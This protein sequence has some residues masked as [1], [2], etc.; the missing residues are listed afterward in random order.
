MTD[1]AATHLAEM[2]DLAA[3]IDVLHHEA[4]GVAGLGRH[5]ESL[6]D[7]AVELG[8]LVRHYDLSPTAQA[9]SL[10]RTALDDPHALP[11]DPAAD[12]ALLMAPEGLR[13]YAIAR[14]DEAMGAL[15]EPEGE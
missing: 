9:L 5:R 13:N 3:R 15:T 7:L 1:P 10:A 12:T 2:R 14:I 11:E 8:E 6:A 4:G